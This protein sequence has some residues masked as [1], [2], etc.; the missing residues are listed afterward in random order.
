MLFITLVF[1]I[2]F[3]LFLAGKDAASYLLKNNS[4]I[5]PLVTSRLQTWHIDGFI[6]NAIFIFVLAYAGDSW[7][8][9]LQGGLVR[10]SIYNI[11]FNYWAG[12]SITYIGTTSWI[13]KNITSKIF[14]SNGAIIQTLTFSII[15]LGLVIFLTWF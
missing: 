3:T 6:I 11:A 4:A 8:I 7:W 10:A 13:D 5:G 9:I 1:S 14:G 15:T 2:V 12:L